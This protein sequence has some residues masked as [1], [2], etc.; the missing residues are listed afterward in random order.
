MS[1]DHILIPFLAVEG[2]FA[3]GSRR[4][5]E[6]RTLSLR[7]GV[8]AGGDARAT[9]TPPPKVVSSRDVSLPVERA[10]SI[11]LKNTHESHVSHNANVHI[12]VFYCRVGT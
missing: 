1:R 8:V 7:P 6:S 11:P 3:R 10:P 4:P 2:P 5:S 12:L 9:Q